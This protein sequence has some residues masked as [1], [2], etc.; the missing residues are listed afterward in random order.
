MC[1]SGAQ[2]QGDGPTQRCDVRKP[3][4]ER[5]RP[6]PTVSNSSSPADAAT[7]RRRSATLMARSCAGGA[8][9]T[10][11]SHVV[12]DRRGPRTME[13]ASNTAAL[14]APVPPKY[15][16]S[17]KAKGPRPH[18]SSAQTYEASLSSSKP[19]TG[20]ATGTPSSRLRSGANDQPAKSG[21]NAL[22]GGAAKTAPVPARATKPKM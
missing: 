11:P 16:A 8:A 13:P 4:L 2:A 15:S 9:N 21:T 20:L 10:L 7:P 1:T 18:A 19:L 6:S 17:T 22:P 12:S 14:C 5:W 3:S